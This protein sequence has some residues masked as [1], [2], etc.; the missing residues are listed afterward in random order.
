LQDCR[1]PNLPKTHPVN[2]ISVAHGDIA[3]VRKIYNRLQTYWPKGDL[4]AVED[5]NKPIFEEE[6]VSWTRGDVST[7]FS[8][9]GQF[10]ESK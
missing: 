10:A 2:M 7:A 3:K 6:G 5:Q 1:A 9:F 4:S 8:L